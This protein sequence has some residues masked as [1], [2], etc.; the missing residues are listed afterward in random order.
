ME[1]QKRTDQYLSFGGKAETDIQAYF[2]GKGVHCVSC[3]K[4]LPDNCIISYPVSN[5]NSI[6]V[7]TTAGEIKYAVPALACPACKYNNTVLK[8]LYQ[9]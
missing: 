3:K 8:L 5:S 1:G 4:D 9:T 2:N 6:S 7:R